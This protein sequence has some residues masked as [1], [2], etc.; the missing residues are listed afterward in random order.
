MQHLPEQPRIGMTGSHSLHHLGPELG[1]DGVGRVE[2]PPVD[3]TLQPV[4]HHPDHQ[5][6][7]FLA[8]MVQAYEGGMPFEDPGC[9]SVRV[10][11]IDV[12]QLSGR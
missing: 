9:R 5:I 8:G 1:G 10:L 4:A 2:T 7:G 12:E 11:P 6:H 3:A